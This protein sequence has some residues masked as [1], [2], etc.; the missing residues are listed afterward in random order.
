MRHARRFLLV[1][2]AAAP[3]Q[4]VASAQE[5]E[6]E[7]ILC[8]RVTQCAGQ[9]CACLEDTLEVTFDGKERSVLSV[10]PGEVGS[11]VRA[12]IVLDTKSAGIQGWSYGVR[13][14]PEFLAV[15][16]VTFDGTDA[17]TA[18]FE[19]F[20]I[21]TAENLEECEEVVPEYECRNPRPGRGWFQA[22][23]LSLMT[24][25]ALPLKRNSLAVAEYTL[26]KL[27]PDAGTLIEVT[28]KIR[29]AGAAVGIPPVAINLTREGQGHE[30]NRIVHGW[31]RGQG[32]PPP[33]LCSNSLDDDGDGL[34]DCA[35]GDCLGGTG[36][37]PPEDCTNKRD[38]DLDGRI[39]CLDDDCW[40]LSVCDEVCGNFADDDMDGKTDC[41][42]EDCIDDPSCIEVCGNSRDDDRDGKSDCYDED[43]VDDPSCIRTDEVCN[44]RKDE[45]FD[46]LIDCKDPDCESSEWCI[47]RVEICW[48]AWDD[49]R[50]GKVDCSDE[51]CAFSPDCFA[52]PGED[53]DNARDDDSD[54]L[55]DCKDPDCAAAPN[56]SV[57]ARENCG[58]GSDD[59]GDERV[60]CADPDCAAFAPCGA[61]FVRG[62]ADGN[63]KINVIDAI[64][65][66]PV[67]DIQRP[68]DCADA[69][70]ADDDG[71]LTVLDTI[72][73]ITYL[74]RHGPELAA[75]HVVCG[76]DLTPDP[77]PCMEA[78]C[79]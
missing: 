25:R 77:L 19:G 20:Q 55:V 35:D 73:L 39:D 21:T 61:L 58:N 68:R 78:P 13:H 1:L 66:V 11:N 59:D 5:E 71:R 53:C 34:T 23:V 62:D 79:P 49:D 7:R 46:S 52:G 42:D 75:P 57:G 18:F 41:R 32:G 28:Y 29:R 76:A 44:N 6:R 3:F 36:C 69:Q 63:F 45:D 72:T 38:D 70:D 40:D 26:E 65:S 54:L 2:A 27:P 4:E 16:A 24:Q 9:V 48:N 15:N 31:L 14:D 64:L 50:D 22:V 12:T 56:C 17:K 10:A 47:P 60:D 74:F 67:G 30:P 33:E 51:D 37:P 43:C 8:D